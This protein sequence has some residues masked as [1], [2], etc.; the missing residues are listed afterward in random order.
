MTYYPHGKEASKIER[1]RTFP[2]YS[3]SPDHPFWSAPSLTE[4]DKIARSAATLNEQLYEMQ[5][6]GTMGSPLRMWNTA[7]TTI[8]LGNVK[9][10]NTAMNLVSANAPILP[11]GQV[12]LDVASPFPR[13]ERS[14]YGFM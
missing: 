2:L 3:T 10:F 9:P 8:P 4:T 11:F 13:N 12:T 7:T 6:M 5:H 14:V 1:E